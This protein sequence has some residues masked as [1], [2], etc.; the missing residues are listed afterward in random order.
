MIST[1]VSNLTADL[2]NPGVTD[3]KKDKTGMKYRELPHKKS[4]E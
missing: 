4:K 3:Q 2:P 1:V